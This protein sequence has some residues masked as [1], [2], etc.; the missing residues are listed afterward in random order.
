MRKLFAEILDIHGTLCFA[1]FFYE[2][3][4]EAGEDLLFAAYRETYMK[5]GVKLK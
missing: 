1:G 4:W 5:P 3:G 2:G